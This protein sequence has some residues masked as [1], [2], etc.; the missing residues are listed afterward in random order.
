MIGHTR[1]VE[2]KIR[3]WIVRQESSRRKQVRLGRVDERHD[4][5]SEPR[6]RAVEF[7]EREH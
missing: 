3:F 5:P 4:V 2:R 6:R 1:Q 7:A